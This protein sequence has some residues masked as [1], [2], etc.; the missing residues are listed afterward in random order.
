MK[1]R[2]K[3]EVVSKGLVREWRGKRYRHYEDVVKVLNELEAEGVDISC[4]KIL[5]SQGTNPWYLFY[6]VEY[7]G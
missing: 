5:N 6:R 3:K 1:A 4:V 7:E 2:V